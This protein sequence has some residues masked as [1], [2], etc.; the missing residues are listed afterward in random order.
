MEPVA[1]TTTLIKRGYWL[2]K[3]RWIATVSIGFCTCIASNVLAITL[4]DSALYSIAILLALYNVTVLLLLNHLAKG[5]RKARRLSVKTIIHFQVSADILILT[6]LLHFSGGIEIFYFIFHMIIAS[7]L[8]SAKESYLQATFAVLLLGLLIL[9][10]YLQVIPH[11]CLRGF[12]VHCSHRNGL[13]VLGTHF[14]FT[15]TMYT[16]VYMASYITT[17]LRKTEEAHREAN[18]LLRR[19]DLIKDEY[20]LRVTHDIKSDL[21]AIQSCL[22]VVIRKLVGS[23]NE[24]QRDL[25]SRADDRTHKLTHFVK[26]LLKLTHMRLCDDNLEMDVF[27]LK[28]IICDVVAAVADKARDKSIILNCNIETLVYKTFGNRSSIEEVITNLL[29]NAVKY[30]P[31]NGTIE[32]NAKGDGGRILVEVTDTGIGIP[33]EELPK[34]FDEF[35]RATNAKKIEKDGTGLG[36]SIVKQI[37]E[38]H[39]GKIWVDSREG[40]G[41]KFSF[42]LPKTA[43]SGKPPSP[44]N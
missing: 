9:F 30:T 26:T 38:R 17:R 19:K 24:Q 14:V 41:T 25:I 2:I 37:I 23:L 34:V 35:Y 12:I 15:T 27:S 13:Y 4:Q 1:E 5:K 43:N 32:V 3:L 40:I 11:H 28:D 22:D 7:I 20:V 31:A 33:Q 16:V 18:T 39:G 42:T 21:A 36:L 10:E 8:L 6:V 29:I 44:I